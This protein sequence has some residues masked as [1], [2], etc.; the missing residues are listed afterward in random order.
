MMRRQQKQHRRRFNGIKTT[1]KA[2]EWWWSGRIHRPVNYRRTTKVG[3]TLDTNAISIDEHCACVNFSTGRD[4]VFDSVFFFLLS[5]LFF[6]LGGFEQR[7]A[8]QTN[9]RMARR[10]ATATATTHTTKARSKS[11]QKI[12]VGSIRR[13]RGFTFYAL[14]TMTCYPTTPLRCVSEIRMRWCVWTVVGP[15]RNACARSLKVMFKL[16]C[17]TKVQAQQQFC[18]VWFGD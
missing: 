10:D 14:S 7:R 15:K 6:V 18:L 4:P 11:K 1:P 12:A 5:K 17:N 8:E 13:F 2:F 9:E 16:I 3:K